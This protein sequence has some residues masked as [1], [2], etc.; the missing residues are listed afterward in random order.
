[1]IVERL[2]AEASVEVTV[3]PGMVAAFEGVVVH[4]VYGTAAMVGHMELAARRVILAARE[5]DEEGVGYRVEVKH[6]TN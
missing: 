1:M 3:S 5:P 2:L 4:A 6:L